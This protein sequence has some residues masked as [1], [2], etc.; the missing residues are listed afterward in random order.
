MQL[1]QRPQK[2]ENA[3][4]VL[5][6]KFVYDTLLANELQYWWRSLMRERMVQLCNLAHIEGNWTRDRC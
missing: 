4:G 3:M 6:W 2:A 1:T 5:S